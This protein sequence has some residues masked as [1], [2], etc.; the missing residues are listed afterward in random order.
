MNFF[1]SVQQPGDQNHIRNKYQQARQYVEVG[2]RNDFIKHFQD[3]VAERFDGVEVIGICANAGEPK[4]HA[5]KEYTETQYQYRKGCTLKF[6][7]SRFIDFEGAEGKA[8]ADDEP[9]GEIITEHSRE[10][11]A[12]VFKPGAGHENGHER[13]QRSKEETE[14]L[15]FP[16]ARK[17]RNRYQDQVD[18]A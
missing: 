3:R 18:I 6:V 13:A 10:Q 8:S 15:K 17:D 14:A 9:V 5:E 12:V 1:F 11:H 7:E 4:R 2:N 16:F